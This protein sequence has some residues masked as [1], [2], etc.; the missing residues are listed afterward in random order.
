MQDPMRAS[1]LVRLRDSHNAEAWQDFVDAYGPLIRHYAKRHGLQDADANDLAQNVFCT[2]ASV[3]RHFAYDPK[4]GSFRQWL[5]TLT[6]NEMYKLLHRQQ[7]LGRGSGDSSVQRAL[8]QQPVEDPLKALWEREY[9]MHLIKW[10][11]NKVRP[12]FQSSS[13]RAFWQTAVQG[14]SAGDVAAKLNMS[15]EAVYTAKSRVLKRIKRTVRQVL[16]EASH[17]VGF[18]R[19]L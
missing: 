11:A 6:R 4:R 17:E 5:L 19:N 18:L 14:R 8:E 3:L 16:G 10:A 9:D 13:W 15:V 12:D 2:I 1:W 7:R